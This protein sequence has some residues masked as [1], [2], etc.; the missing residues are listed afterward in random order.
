M[1]DDIT[2]TVS[3]VP[4]MPEIPPRRFWYLP[5]IISSYKHIAFIGCVLHISVLVNIGYFDIDC[6]LHIG[7]LVIKG[8][9]KWVFWY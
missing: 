1:A 4:K 3:T 6:I 2:D 7:V 9:M 5:Y 8:T